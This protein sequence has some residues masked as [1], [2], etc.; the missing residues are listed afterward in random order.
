[1]KKIRLS[2]IIRLLALSVICGI[3]G[4][5]SKILISSWQVSQSI[6]QETV[7]QRNPV[8]NKKLINKAVKKI[9]LFKSDNLTNIENDK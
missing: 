3:I 4:A 6:D 1:M 5:S 9:N 7:D 8:L 2:L